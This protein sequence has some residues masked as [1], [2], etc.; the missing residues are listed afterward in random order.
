M[1]RI[2]Q[3]GGNGQNDSFHLPNQIN[4]LN[5]RFEIKLFYSF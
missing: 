2:L 1:R 3:S 5:R 4:Q